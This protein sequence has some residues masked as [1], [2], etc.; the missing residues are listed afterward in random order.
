L[1]GL[2]TDQDLEL[3]EEEFPGI[4]QFYAHCNGQH[5]TFLSLLAAYLGLRGDTAH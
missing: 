4:V 5:R 1:L 3:A 2:V